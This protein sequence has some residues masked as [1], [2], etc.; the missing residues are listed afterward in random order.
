MVKRECG[1]ISTQLASLVFAAV[2]AGVLF[3]G[4]VIA[5]AFEF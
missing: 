2:I 4:G 1:S 3:V 5:P